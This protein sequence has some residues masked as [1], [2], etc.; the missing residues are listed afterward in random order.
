MDSALVYNF[1]HLITFARGLYSVDD[2]NSVLRRELL[3]QGLAID[4]FQLVVDN[5]TQRVGACINA[6]DGIY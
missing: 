5:A 3:S 6:Q 2:I 4:T 1:H